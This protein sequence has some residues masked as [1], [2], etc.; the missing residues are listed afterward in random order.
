VNDTIPLR[1]IVTKLQQA[2]TFPGWSTTG[3]SFYLTPDERLGLN[4]AAWCSYTLR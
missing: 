1:V 2:Q 3:W 4:R